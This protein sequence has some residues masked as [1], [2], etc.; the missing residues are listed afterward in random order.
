VQISNE[1]KKSYAAGN[2]VD[3][4]P[5]LNPTLSG[6][7][8]ATQKIPR[9]RFTVEPKQILRAL[10]WVHIIIIQLDPGENFPCSSPNESAKI[11]VI[12]ARDSILR[13]GEPR[14][15][16]PHSMLPDE[17]EI[18]KTIFLVWKECFGNHP[19]G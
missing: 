6:R 3:R 19:P 12:H 7:R 4:K 9:G 13:E 5:G 2:G 14:R 1:K 15:S 8:A 10:F 18:C 16:D 11:K 17:H